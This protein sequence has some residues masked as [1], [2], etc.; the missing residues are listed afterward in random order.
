[1]VHKRETLILFSDSYLTNLEITLTLMDVL[2]LILI[3]CI[4]LKKLEVL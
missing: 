2:E 4:N 3:N 1:V